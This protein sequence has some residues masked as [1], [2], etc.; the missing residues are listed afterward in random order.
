MDPDDMAVM[1]PKLPV[2]RGVM[3]VDCKLMGRS[4]VEG[5]GPV[6]STLLLSALL[7]A[8]SLKAAAGFYVPE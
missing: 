5:P 8:L 1:M 7:M 4:P 3:V 2:G 6:L